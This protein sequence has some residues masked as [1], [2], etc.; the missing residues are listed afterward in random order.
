M[1]NASVSVSSISHQEYLDFSIFLEKSCGIVLGENKQYLVDSRL[2]RLLIE[3]GLNTLGDLVTQLKAGHNRLL[4]EH[5]IDAMT[6]NETSWFRDN[7]PYTALSDMILPGII[8]TGKKN[9]R[10]WSSAC[11]SG[12]EPY[13]ISIII[14]ECR[15]LFANL[16]AEIMATDISPTM[17]RSAREGVFDSLSIARG[18]SDSRKSK[19]FKQVANSWA[20]NSDLKNN[21]SFKEVN[22]QSSFNSL[23]K[24]DVIFCR[25]VLIYFSLPLKQDIIHRMSQCLN[26][27]GYL[28]LG[29]TE[30]ALNYSG[31]FV[32]VRHQN[33]ILYKKT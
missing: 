13:S 25:N 33:G 8:S 7:F 5:T 31:E 26:P 19:Y 15:G 22:L 30:S 12:Q 18:L 4:R 17:L 28:I 3:N 10:I 23:G 2:K 11:S 21:I 1:I 6:T 16:K 27:G 24:F 9:I 20:I 32:P 29:G 14:D